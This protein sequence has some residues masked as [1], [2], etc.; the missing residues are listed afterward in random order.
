MSVWGTPLRSWHLGNHEYVF[1]RYVLDKVCRKQI[2]AKKLVLDAGCGEYISSL[3]WVPKETLAVCVDVSKQNVLKSQRLCRKNGENNFVYL[4]CSVTALPFK[5]GTFDLIVS[6]DVIEH[7]PDNNGLVE[8]TFRVCRNGGY[9]VGSTS[10][11]LNPIFLFDSYM[12]KSVMDKLTARFAGEHYDRHTR[13]TF[14]ALMDVLSRNRF[15]VTGIEML[16]YPLFKASLYQYHNKRVPWYGY[17]WI[18]FDKL[19]NLKPLRYLKESIVFC[20]KKP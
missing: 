6:Q 15:S 8:E 9:F 1:Y 12:P 14:K 3:S 2:A 13:L 5:D 10:N 16:G 18:I 7:V 19:T 17:F 11:L 4:R 20:T